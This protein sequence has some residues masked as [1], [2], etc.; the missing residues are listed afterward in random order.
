MRELDRNTYMGPLTFL[1]T[2][3]YFLEAF[4]DGVTNF[5]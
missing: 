4:L 1:N 5:L 2:R 3:T